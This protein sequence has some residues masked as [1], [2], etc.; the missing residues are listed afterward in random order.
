MKP[1]DALPALVGTSW[2]IGNNPD[3][4]D[5]T[6]THQEVVDHAIYR[7][8][9]G[10][11][12]L[13]ACIRG[14]RVGRLLYQWRGQSLEEPNW[15]PLGIAMRAEQRYGE[16]IDDWDG[17]EWIQA[18]HVIEHAGRYWMFYGGHNSEQGVCQI[19]LATS[20]D[21]ERF[22][23]HRNA[24]GFSRVFLGPGEA[25]DPMVLRVEDR[26]LCYYAGHDAGQ[27]SPGKIYCR[28]SDDLIAWSDPQPV[29]WG[30]SAGDGPWSAE[31]PFV[32]ARDGACYL[33]R[34]SRYAPPARTHVYRSPDPLDFGGDTDQCL[35]TTL[36]VAAPEVVSWQGQ[37]YISSVEDLRGGVRLWRLA[38][39]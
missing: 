35:L 28:T 15:E 39:L 38:W 16:S 13:W 17:Q 20:E 6:G 31:C 24:Q 9:D 22:E 32:V 26:W 10:T 11:W 4:G 2:P 30:G 36:Q 8:R 29:N 7:A 3:L 23:R 1:D 12:R 19:C 14:T 34:T 25:R 18:P 21:G 37:D 27:R 5:L 33:F